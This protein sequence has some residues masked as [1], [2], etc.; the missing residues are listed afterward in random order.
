[1]YI[2]VDVNGRIYSWVK[3]GLC[4]FF[5]ERII[6]IMMKYVFFQYNKNKFRNNDD[7]G[8]NC[9]IHIII[10]IPLGY[11]YLLNSLGSIIYAIYIIIYSN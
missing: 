7:D 3:R 1:M 8:G 10:V 2:I 9:S 6:P 5:K 4:Q 11:H